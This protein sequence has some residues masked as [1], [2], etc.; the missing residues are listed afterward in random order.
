MTV[1]LTPLNNPVR[2]VMEE[3]AKHRAD[4]RVL[5][6]FICT[7]YSIDL[8]PEELHN[9]SAMNIATEAMDTHRENQRSNYHSKGLP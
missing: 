1:A 6:L 5:S 9:N 3:I 2:E 7:I 4:I 8:L